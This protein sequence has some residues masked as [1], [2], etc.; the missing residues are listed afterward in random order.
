HDALPISEAERAGQVVE[1]I[2]V[3]HADGQPEPLVEA[4]VIEPR[5]VLAGEG[6]AGHM[7]GD[8]CCSCHMS[9]HQPGW[10]VRDGDVAHASSCGT[11]VAGCGPGAAGTATGPARRWLG[12]A[13]HTRTCAPCLRSEERRG[14]QACATAE[15]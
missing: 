6:H 12:K 8:A 1:P 15:A 2:V 9:G 5:E 3:M 10:C 4:L 13:H 7:R 14:G 11:G